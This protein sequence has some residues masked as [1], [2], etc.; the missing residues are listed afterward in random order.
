MKER[1][2]TKRKRKIEKKKQKEEKKLSC[3]PVGDMPDNTE[4]DKR[5][6][7]LLLYM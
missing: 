5:A 2:Q 4:G 3:P 6:I 7:A 1:K